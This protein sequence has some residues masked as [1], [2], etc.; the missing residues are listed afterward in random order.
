MS[1]AAEEEDE[2]AGTSCG[3]AEVDGVK[4]EE[5]S[6][7]DEEFNSA[8]H[9]MTENYLHNPMKHISVTA[10]SASCRCRLIRK[11]LRF[12]HAA[13]KSFVWAVKH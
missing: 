2:R 8:D 7:H 6:E 1:N 5:S 11:N 12:G 10:L 9:C 4:S 13:A 3:D